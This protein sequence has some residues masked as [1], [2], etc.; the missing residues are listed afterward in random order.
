MMKGNQDA[1]GQYRMLALLNSTG[2]MA[3]APQSIPSMGLRDDAYAQWQAIMATTEY[4]ETSIAE[5]NAM[6][7]SCADVRAL[8]I[9]SFGDMPL[10][11]LS[12]GREEAIPSLSDAENQ[13]LWKEF[14][15]ER[16]EFAAL[17]SKSKQ[18]IAERS[19]HFI[20]REQPDLVIDAIQE[21]LDAF[22]K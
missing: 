3:L 9:T 5:I 19:G 16:S 13:Q 12:A 15:I 1:I 6:S 14:Q 2:I 17:S 18:I 20:Q 22:R 11:V 7:E 21:I 8:S 10:I 4:F